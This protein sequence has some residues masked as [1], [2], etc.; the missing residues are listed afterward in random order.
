MSRPRPVPL[1]LTLLVLLT[2]A[3][4]ARA[5]APPVAQ[6]SLSQQIEDSRHHFEQGVALYN[7]GDFSGA[8]AEF[9]GSYKAHPTVGVLYNI[10]LTLKALRRYTDAMAK[11]SQYLAED[12]KLSAER[13]NEIQKLITEM[14]ALLADV[15][16][17][18]VPDGAAV[19]VDGRTIGTSPL[20]AVGIPAGNHVID[21]TA[22]GYRPARKEIMVTAGVPMAVELKLAVIPKTG[23]V[24]VAASQPLAEVKIDDKPFGRAPVEA[25]L[26]IGGHRLEVTALGYQPNRSEVVVA[27]GQSRDLFITLELPPPPTRRAR[28]YDKWWFWSITGALVVGGTVATVVAL[29]GTE[30]PLKGPGWL[31]PVIQPVN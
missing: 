14:R 30:G 25:E 11:L 5:Q 8:L 9:E 18:V 4:A 6:P 26:I 7:D 23:K 31:D 2:S 3:Q 17:Y 21:V 20:R 27:G 1:R 22:D 13:F 29:S 10:G 24:R 15:T 19:L 12:K 16:I 28:F